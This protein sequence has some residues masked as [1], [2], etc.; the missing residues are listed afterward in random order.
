M[1]WKVTGAKFQYDGKP[2]KAMGHG[3]NVAWACAKCSHPI[4]FEYRQAGYGSIPTNPVRCPEC[5]MKY[6][7]EPKWTQLDP[8]EGTKL[9]ADVMTITVSRLP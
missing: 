2:T 8:E 7:L 9:A 3:N 4:L 1:G 5:G 6:Y